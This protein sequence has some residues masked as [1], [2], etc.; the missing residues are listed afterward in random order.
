MRDPESPSCKKLGTP[1]DRIEA[2]RPRLIVFDAPRITKT[3]VERRA[4][5]HEMR[6]VECDAEMRA[7][8]AISRLPSGAGGNA[9]ERPWKYQ[10]SFTL[11]H[12]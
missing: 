8:D 3:H 12:P 11:V 6:V 7:P 1:R 5:I 2:V 9:I 4:R 10:P